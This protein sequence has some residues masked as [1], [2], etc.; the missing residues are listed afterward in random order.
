MHRNYSL[1]HDVVF[2]DATYTTNSMSMPLVVFTGVNHEGKN[3]LLGYAFLQSETMDNY[4]WVLQQLVEQNRGIMPR[5][6]LTDFDSSMCGAIERVFQGKTEH[7][8]CQWHM[9]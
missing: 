4:I 6:L 2:M 8:L 5:V 9:M 7:L 1:Y 3:T